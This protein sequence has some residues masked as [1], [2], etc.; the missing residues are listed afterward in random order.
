MEPKLSSVGVRDLRCVVIP[1]PVLVVLLDARHDLHRVF[2]PTP[3]P[4]DPYR[5]PLLR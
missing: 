2:I 1:T 4:L 3:V 5:H